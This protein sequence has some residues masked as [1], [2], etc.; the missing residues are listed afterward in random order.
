MSLRPQSPAPRR[1]SPRPG[2]PLCS[3]TGGDGQYP[4]RRHGVVLFP[5][6]GDVA[7]GRDDQVRFQLASLR[8]IAIIAE[9]SPAN[10]GLFGKSGHDCRTG[11]TVLQ[12]G[13]EEFS[14]EKVPAAA[15]CRLSG[16]HP[17]PPA[18]CRSARA[19]LLEQAQPPGGHPPDPQDPPFHGE[20]GHGLRA[21]AG[22][23][24]LRGRRLV[25]DQR[26]RH[27]RP[28]FPGWPSPRALSASPQSA[29][30]APSAWGWS[31]RTPGPSSSSGR[32]AGP[33]RRSR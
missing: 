24:V 11:P 23:R 30:R 15:F 16:D 21:G 10:E 3:R 31:W 19:G 26:R 22:Q 20:Q 14:H 9:N 13:C 2:R 32:C 33:G 25:P 8:G 6:L 12:F 17:E 4:Q 27:P 5:A 7:A 28:R 1:R 29:T 18:G